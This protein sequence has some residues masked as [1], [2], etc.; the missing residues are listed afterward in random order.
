M[1][2]QRMFLEGGPTMYFVLCIAALAHLGGLAGLIVALVRK[3]R[4]LALGLG[5]VGIVVV[6]LL[7]A[8]GFLGYMY[9]MS[10]TEA[11]LASVDPTVREAILAQGRSE[12]MNNIWFSLCSAA[13]PLAFAIV[14]FIRGA[15]LPR[16]SVGA[17]E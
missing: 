9:G 4:S 3:K 2:P 8:V 12:S 13:M 16:E 14:L 17:R 7:L 15:M 5:S 1:D 10:R 6:V 11:A